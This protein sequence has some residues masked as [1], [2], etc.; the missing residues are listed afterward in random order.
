MSYFN[1]PQASRG[2]CRPDVPFNPAHVPPITP[3]LAKMGSHDPNIKDY[4]SLACRQ[5]WDDI[6]RAHAHIFDR[7]GIFRCLLCQQNHLPLQM[8]SMS[9]L[10]RGIISLWMNGI[11]RQ[12]T[13]RVSYHST[14]RVTYIK[15]F[16][17]S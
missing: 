13:L 6:E 3:K 9:T 15:L 5:V 2:T 10:S 14:H 8:L 7:F 16:L 12:E 11:E 1:P 4:R 17:R